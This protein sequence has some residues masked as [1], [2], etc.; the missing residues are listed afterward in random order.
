MECS[1]CGKNN[2]FIITPPDESGH[3]CLECLAKGNKSSSGKNLPNV[4][5]IQE[6][7]KQYCPPNNCTINLDTDSKQKK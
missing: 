6:W 5:Q 1:I 3:Y 2:T 7:L 4:V